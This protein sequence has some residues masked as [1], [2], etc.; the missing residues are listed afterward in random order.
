MFWWENSPQFTIIHFTQHNDGRSDWKGSRGFHCGIK[1]MF[2]LSVTTCLLSVRLS[3][4]LNCEQLSLS[5]RYGA[6]CLLYIA[7]S[8]FIDW[9]C[10]ATIV[11]EHGVTNLTKLSGSQTPEGNGSRTYA[12]LDESTREAK[13]IEYENLFHG[14]VNASPSE[15]LSKTKVDCLLDI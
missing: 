12:S 9:K 13:I 10:R 6:V 15:N 2:N 3:R 11:V 14:Y 1:S 4:I 7:T 5:C 8:S